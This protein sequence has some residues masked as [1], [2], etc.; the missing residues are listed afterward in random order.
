MRNARIGRAARE[1]IVILGKIIKHVT[2]KDRHVARRGHMPLGCQPVHVLEGRA[3]HA[4][5]GGGAVHP[6]GI[7]RLG[8]FDGH[9]DGM[10]R[11]I[12]RF[13]RRGTNQI[14]QLDFLTGAQSQLAGR[15]GCGLARDRHIGVK[16]DLAPLD[17]LKRDIERH[18]LGQRGRMQSG[19]GILGM[20]HFSIPRIHDHCRIWRC[21]HAERKHNDQPYGCE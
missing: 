7:G 1:Q 12:G 15:L 3:R 19:V 6:A 11:V 10:G 4:H 18:H 17:G 8:P 2:T 20:E 13:D 9:S 14:T 5:R 21:P 16:T